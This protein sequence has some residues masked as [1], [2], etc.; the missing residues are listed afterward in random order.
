MPRLPKSPPISVFETNIA[1]AETL[2]NLSRSLNNQRLRG[3]RRELRESFGSAMRISKRDQAGLDCVE[4]D[5]LFVIIKSTGS[6]SREDFSEQ[7]LRPLL[8]QAI[9]SVAAAVESY[10]AEKAITYI[11]DALDSGSTRI[12]GVNVTLRDVFDI[13]QTLTRRRFGWRRIL[14]EKTERE[15]SA[16]PG[17]IESVFDLVGK[18]VRWSAIDQSRR[19]Q[20]GRSREQMHE[21]ADRRNR[22]AHTGDRVGSGRAAISIGDTQ[23]HL[24]NAKAVIEVLDKLL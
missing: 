9:V 19:V 8:R 24:G 15:A 11:G 10:V 13:E 1:D 14:Q 5:D 16:S 18:P 22:I 3:M 2:L 21:L 23:K 6:R 4:S 7:E 17:K 20:R 12:R